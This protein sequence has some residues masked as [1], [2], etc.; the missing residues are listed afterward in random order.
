MKKA[1]SIIVE[2]KKKVAFNSKSRKII[3]KEGTN[4]TLNQK[5]RD[6]IKA[7]TNSDFGERM[8]S[9][10]FGILSGKK[11]KIIDLDKLFL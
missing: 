5:D 8:A 9:G 7:W 3:T 2:V 11:G 6:I 10:G 1:K 4:N